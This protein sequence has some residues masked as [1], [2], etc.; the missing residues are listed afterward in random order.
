[1]LA[2]WSTTLPSIDVGSSELQTLLAWFA[3]AVGD[4]LPAVIGLAVL[5]IG[6]AVVFRR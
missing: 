6:I 1:M 3:A 4:L 2:E 5:S